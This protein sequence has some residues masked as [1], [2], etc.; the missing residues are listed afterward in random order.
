MGMQSN[1]IRRHMRTMAFSY[2]K[3]TFVKVSHG[4]LQKNSTSA[5]SYARNVDAKKV[6]QH[7]KILLQM[8]VDHV[9]RIKENCDEQDGEKKVCTNLC[10]NLANVNT[11]G[12]YTHN[13]LPGKSSRFL[14]DKDANGQDNAQY[15]T[16]NVDKNK[17]STGTKAQEY[18]NKKEI[19]NAPKIDNYTSDPTISKKL[20]E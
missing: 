3:P 19:K 15:F 16:K 13:P 5:M 17:K 2:I 18:Y 7:Q 8:I 1:I 4:V 9:H 20:D 14:S 12:H 10:S 6:L 11:D